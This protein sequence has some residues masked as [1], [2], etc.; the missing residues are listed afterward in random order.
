MEYLDQVE[1]KMRAR[2]TLGSVLN[3][4]LKQ[5]EEKHRRTKGGLKYST[6]PTLF[7]CLDGFATSFIRLYLSNLKLNVGPADRRTI[8][9]EGATSVKVNASR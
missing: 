3:V 8:L 7:A 5:H 6:V 2:A 1:G 9:N 4:R